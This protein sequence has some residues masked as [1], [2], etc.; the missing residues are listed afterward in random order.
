MCGIAGVLRS[1]PHASSLLDALAHRGPDSQGS[2]DLDECTLAATRLAI[3]DPTSRADQP[4]TH[5]QATIVLNGEIYNFREL[6]D[7]LVACGWSFKTSGDTEVLLKAL[8]QWGTG[9]LARV[10]GMYAFLLWL[11]DRRELWAA[12]DRFGIKP[13]YWGRLEGGGVCFGSEARAVTELTGCRISATG[14]SEFLHFGSPYSSTAF[15]GVVEVPPGCVSIWRRDRSVNVVSLGAECGLGRASLGEEV[16]RS[17]A[18]HLVSDRPVALFLSGGFDSAMVASQLAGAARPPTAFTID[19]GRNGGDVAAARK[20]ARHYGL[21]HRVV[22]YSKSEV[23]THVTRY[24]RS[25]DQPTIDGFNTFLISHAVNAHGFPVALSGLGGDEVF[26]GY[27]YYRRRRRLAAASLAYLRAGRRARE[28]MSSLIASRTARTPAQIAGILE[29]RTP[30]DRYRAWRCLFTPDEVERLTGCT[31]GAPTVAGP[32]DDGDDR[33]TFRALDF[34]W[35][36]RST[37][38]RDTDV[39]SMAC[40][41]ELRVPLL[42][43]ALVETATGRRPRLDKPAAAAALGDPHLAAVA[44][45]PKVA[46]RLPWHDWLDALDCGADLMAARDPWRGCVDPA[47]A[48]RLLGAD[49]NQGVDRTLALVILAR[50]LAEVSRPRRIP[51]RPV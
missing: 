41:V 34:D 13:L 23:A 39:F 38:L 45:A 27:G 21:I 7:Q 44:G 36:L 11:G 48:R 8:L 28:A 20:T 15:D 40:G 26:G 18:G 9:A 35:Y 19:T 30:L 32:S 16:R 49:R 14:L 12:R 6:R 5:G 46:F 1:H 33:S 43:P 3:L 42:D 4:V 50:W 25:M 29:A 31:P 10:Q 37:L 24:L 22:R 2:A 17:V 51:R 47:E